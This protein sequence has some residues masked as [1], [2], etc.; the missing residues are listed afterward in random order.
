[1]SSN[2]RIAVR[3]LTAKKRAMIMSLSCIILGVGLFV[4]TQAT[5]TGFEGFFIKTVL[6]T[7]G[8]IRVQDEIQ[9]TIRTMSAGGSNSK[10]VIRQK[11]GWKFVDGIA[12]PKLVIEGLKE[13]ANVAA[14]SPVLRGP[15]TINTSFGHDAVHVY[16]I[17]LETYLK[18]SDLEHQ[19]VRGSLADFRATPSG[20]L[21]GSEIARRLQLVP[22]DSFVLETEGQRRHFRVSGIYETGVSDIDRE[23]VYLD[24]SAARSLLKKPVGATYIQVNL[25]DKDRAPEDAQRM[26]EV[27]HHSARPWQEREKAWLSAFGALSISSA[28]TVSVFT[29]IAGLAMFNTLAMMVIEKTKEIAI[30]RSMGYER[31]DITRI[32]LWQA[33][34]VLVIG[35][36]AGS[37]LG[38]AITLAVSHTPL[39]H[40]GISGIFSTKYFKVAWSWWHYLEAVV[41]AVIVV[42]VASLIPARR[43]ARLEPGDVI[44][45]SAQ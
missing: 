5:T 15:V 6:G 17:D 29:L 30:L 42:M 14:I 32:F 31:A 23:R 21:V 7:D 34:I 11:E 9:E 33:A 24:M 16:G 40:G 26:E 13:F 12:E 3:F 43:A 4:V 38:A 18:V 22:G 35:A 2:L 25:L 44:R 27:L 36:V 8:A 28:I 19:I 20:A 37:A 39:P 1:M 10:F 41:T 45:G